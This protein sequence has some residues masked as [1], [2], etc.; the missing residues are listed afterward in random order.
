PAVFGRI[1]TAASASIPSSEPAPAGDTRRIATVVTAVPEASSTRLSTSR[2][3]APPVPTMSREP[4]V[5]PAST[6][7][8]PANWPA[9]AAVGGPAA[10]SFC[11]FVPVMSSSLH[12][13]DDLDLVAAA[14]QPRRP[15]TARDD[16]AVD[17]GRDT[18]GQASDR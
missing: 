12:G 6:H 14:E 9:G 10:A 4:R 8:S 15:G 13:R 1:C 5:R 3:G 7:G 11:T 16:L 2:L 18:A 17:G